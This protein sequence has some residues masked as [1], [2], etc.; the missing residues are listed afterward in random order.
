MPVGTA[1]TTGRHDG[2]C[3][4]GLSE[5]R[6]CLPSRVSTCLSC[7]SVSLHS[8]CFTFM[9]GATWF[10]SCSFSSDS[11]SRRF[12]IALLYLSNNSARNTSHIS[13]TKI[14][15]V[16]SQIAT[17]PFYSPFSG[18]IRVSRRQKRTD[19]M[20]QGKNNSGR[21]TDHPAGR[22]SIQTNRLG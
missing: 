9:S 12:V 17:Q 18:T 14:I 3:V 4:R 11:A 1:V 8:R 21:H 2:S 19:S 16:S 10:C 20:V 7:S 22:H 15:S 13:V 6:V 5:A